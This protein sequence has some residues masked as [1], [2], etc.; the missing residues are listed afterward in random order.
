MI[1]CLTVSPFVVGRVSSGNRLS[2]SVYSFRVLSIR[3]S[4][5]GLIEDKVAGMA[6]LALMSRRHLPGKSTSRL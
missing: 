5:K 2:N 1:L 3:L 4:D 6:S